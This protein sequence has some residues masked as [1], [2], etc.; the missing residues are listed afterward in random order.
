[1]CR[2]DKMNKEGRVASVMSVGNGYDRI[3]TLTITQFRRLIE[4]PA[5]VCEC[6]IDDFGP[7]EKE[8]IKHLKIGSADYNEFYSKCYASAL[9]KKRNKVAIEKYGI[10]TKDEVKEDNGEE[11]F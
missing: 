7:N 4:L 1:M 8:F 3:G 10:T 9:R 6:T 11:D 2:I 5:W